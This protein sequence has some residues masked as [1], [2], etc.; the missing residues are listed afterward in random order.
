MHF[1]E[2]ALHRRT[3]NLVQDNAFAPAG[4]PVKQCSFRDGTAEHLLKTHCLCAELKAILI[5][6]FAGAAFILDGVWPPTTVLSG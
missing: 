4:L 3:K 6:V 5:S 1:R 2:S